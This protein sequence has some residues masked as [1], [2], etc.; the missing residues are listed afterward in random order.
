MPSVRLVSAVRFR[1]FRFGS[2]H[3]GEFWFCSGVVGL[4]DFGNLLGVTQ[5]FAGLI[6]LDIGRICV[7]VLC[8]S[9][10][11]GMIRRFVSY[12]CGLRQMRFGILYANFVGLSFVQ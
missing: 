3:A 2:C 5:C 9:C 4:N 7:R 6:R 12:R 10:I 1:R 8:I 11:A